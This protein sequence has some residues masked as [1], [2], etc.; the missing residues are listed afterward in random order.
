MVERV[1]ADASSFEEIEGSFRA[2]SL[3]SEKKLI[4]FSGLFSS[5]IKNKILTDKFFQFVF[6]TENSVVLYESSDI[7]KNAR[8]KKLPKDIRVV[9]SSKLTRRDSINW[10]VNNIQTNGRAS[11][12]DAAAAY[13]F[14]AFLGDMWA[15]YNE[16]LKM[17]AL[18]YPSAVSKKDVE[19]KVFGGFSRPTQIY[20]RL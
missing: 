20:S 19:G 5:K 10:L 8:F 14:D 9:S 3:F 6:E 12:E 11:I 15:S 4:I 13:V 18:F 7:T 16:L 17:E 2:A 1:D